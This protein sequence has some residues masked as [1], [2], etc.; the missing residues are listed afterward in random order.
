MAMKKKAAGNRPAAQN[1]DS[2]IY[3]VMIALGVL[4]IA[5]LG[6]QMIGRTYG[7][8]DGI[9]SIRTLVTW[10]TGVFGAGALAVLVLGF[11]RGKQMPRFR[12]FFF[13]LFVVLALFAFACYMLRLYWVS[14]IPYLYFVFIA[15]TVLY[16]IH[17]LYQMEF[18]LL[19]LC[20]VVAGLLFYLFSRMYPEGRASA[21]SL[22]L[23]A[24][25][26]VLL[27]AVATLAFLCA[28]N[29][30]KLKWKE[31][32][33]RVFQPRFSPL[34]LYL[35]A[36]IWIVCAVAAFFLGSA[37]AYYCMF[38]AAAWELIFAVYYTFKLS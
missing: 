26:L 18:F 27:L 32:A 29:N 8:V 3:K 10:G 2:V 12:A 13:P 38:G 31:T 1:D 4:C 28:R 14:P 15:A 36:A 7:T 6:L 19:S 17:L 23:N 35:T 5:V 22:I 37:V 16:M 25:L 34:P 21:N 30:G 20:N 24:G 9:T 11:V 33:I